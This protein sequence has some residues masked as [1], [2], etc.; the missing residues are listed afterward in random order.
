MDDVE[1]EQLERRLRKSVTGTRPPAPEALVQ[2]VETVPVRD[3][4][5]SRIAMTLRR[6]RVRR[7]VMAVAAAAAVVVALIGSA[8]IMAVRTSQTGQS[9]RDGWSWQRADGT[10]VFRPFGVARGFVATCRTSLQSESSLCTSP[11]GLHWTTPADP[12]I[13]SVE[14][15]G[16]FEPLQM[17]E[18]G[19]VYLAGTMSDTA[20]ARA[21][22]DPTPC[23]SPSGCYSPGAVPQAVL[24]RSGNGIHWSRVDSAAFSGLS[25]TAVGTIPGGFIVVAASTPE[26]TGWALTSPDGLNWSRSSQL[27]VQPG[28][29]ESEGE[30]GV[31]VGGTS[32]TNE[33]GA[34]RTLDGKE[35]TR[36][37]L[38]AG[39][40]TL[41]SVSAVRSGGYVGMGVGVQSPSPGYS[42]LRS[43]D[44]S[45]WRVDP[46]DLKGTL[47]GLC[48][49]GDRLVA[50]VAPDP[51]TAET[52]L[53][54]LRIWESLD[55]G[56]TW[57]LLLDPTGQQMSGM[58][59]PMGDGLAIETPNASNAPELTWVGTLTGRAAPVPLTSASRPSPTPTA[60]NTAKPSA[61]HSGPPAADVAYELAPMDSA[62]PP[63]GTADVAA[64]VLRSRLAAIG[65]GGYS[66]AVEQP[67]QIH[68]VVGTLPAGYSADQLLSR[69]ASTGHLE[70][71]LLP[72]DAYGTSQ[73]G[74]TKPVPAQGDPIDPTLPAQFTG[75]Q[76]DPGGI[77][78][79]QDPQNLGYWL[80]DFAWAGAAGD[81]FAIWTGAHV[82][83]YMA[84]VLDGSVLS[85]PYIFSEVTG[86][87]GQISGNFSQADAQA[88]AAILKSGALPAP[89]RQ[90]PVPTGTPAS[91]DGATSQPLSS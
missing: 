38:P 21:S 60:P 80:V 50:S 70:F 77:S 45:T 46:G 32:S 1:F 58:A 15:G 76:L 42:M 28:T 68:V 83:D 7:S 41:S 26:E 4:A 74:G 57:Q 22:A 63:G 67:G 5:K 88:V 35:W 55:W 43:Q 59:F 79:A 37:D 30:A 54:S 53:T 33:N 78:A 16:Q 47:I 6:P 12:A 87:K 9:N 39:V 56:Q 27:P 89:L 34:W 86:G 49:V 51:L 64:A 66:V 90:V 3:R 24:W 13:V 81:Q 14:G 11:D 91:T 85:V 82:N 40:D 10:I 25:L 48:V 29:S 62:V 36:L 8:A 17:V 18:Y 84:I 2:F 65:A 71:V 44:G 69:L 31:F 20:Y 73:A 19:G 61:S 52:P 72:P 75:D 23:L